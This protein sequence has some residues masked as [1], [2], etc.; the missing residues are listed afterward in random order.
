[1]SFFQKI[2]YLGNNTVDTDNKVSLLAEYFFT[3]NHGLI[4]NDNFI[5]SEPGLYHTSVNDLS[6]GGIIKISE[7]FDSIEMLDQPRQEWSHVKS[8]LATYKLMRELEKQGRTV[9][10]RSNKN[11]KGYTEFEQLVE[12]NK[13]FCIYPWINFVLESDNKLQLCARS[14]PIIQVD[15]LKDWKTDSTYQNIRNK[16]IAGEPLPRLC[17]VCYDYEAVGAE[18]YRQYETREWLNQLEIQSLEDLNKIDNPYYYEIRLS[19]KCNAM[20]RGCNPSYSHLIEKESKKFNI[21]PLTSNIIKKYGTIDLININ[22]LSDKHRV[23]LTGGEPTIMTEVLQFMKDCIDKNKTNFEFTISTNGEKFSHK[24]L[25]LSESFTNMNFSFSL[26]GY[27]KINDYWRWKTNWDNII[28]NMKTVEKMGHSVHINCVPGIYNVTNLHL[29]YEF[30]DQEFPNTTVY[31]QLNYFELNS[32]FNHPDHKL[33]IDS[34]ER[35][36]KTKTYYSDGKSNKTV[37]DSLHDY[38]LKN[39]KFNADLLKQFFEYNDKLDLARNSKLADYI[40]E[41][42]N[43]RKYIN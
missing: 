26:D 13:S 2:L 1:M 21:I 4:D 11:I 23:Y 9:K 22:S 41:L 25:K 37:I 3:K 28:R 19:N 24:F 43:C 33:V 35:C 7:Y 40:P 42:E 32:A 27:G 29:L 12:T 17:K 20:C 36:K 10:F 30:L 18:S 8:L 39:P 16:M 5:P 34:M 38:Y 15:K 14:L 6:A 31:L